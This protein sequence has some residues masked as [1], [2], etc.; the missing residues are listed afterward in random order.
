M[1][2]HI[3][4][5]D[6][7]SAMILNIYV[8]HVCT[9][10][11]NARA[12]GL[13]AAAAVIAIIRAIA[14]ETVSRDWTW[15]CTNVYT[16]MEWSRAIRIDKP[17]AYKSVCRACSNARLW[18]SIGRNWDVNSHPR[19]QQI[20]LCLF[21]AAAI[22]NRNRQPR[23]ESRPMHTAIIINCVNPPTSG[24]L[25]HAVREAFAAV[26]LCLCRACVTPT[27][28]MDANTHAFTRLHMQRT[29]TIIENSPKRVQ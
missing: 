21:Y 16:Y 19:A 8:R 28:C 6:L 24:T 5:L 3:S 18:T 10:G 1:K 14:Y 11:M 7:P 4:Q 25:T 20:N 15:T 12:A 2:L 26:R 29:L 9:V 23:N 27:G 22:K 13:V 17:R